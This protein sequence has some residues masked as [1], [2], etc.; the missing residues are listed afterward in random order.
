MGTVLPVIPDLSLDE[1]TY[2][3]VARRLMKTSVLIISMLVTLTPVCAAGDETR[4]QDFV[5]STLS[6]VFDKF[7]KYSSGE[8]GVFD[9]ESEGAQYRT[10][11]LGH[12]I[13]AST[14]RRGEGNSP[15]DSL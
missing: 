10:D 3:N 2:V 5:S 15:D 8:K 6:T 11:A 9:S 1:G 7:D 13:P 14:R 12:R 4:G